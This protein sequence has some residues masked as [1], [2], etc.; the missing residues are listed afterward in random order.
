MNGLT[1]GSES[2]FATIS[3]RSG[4]PPK[5]KDGIRSGCEESAEGVSGEIQRCSFP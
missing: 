4:S 5:K 3:A 1:T 2:I